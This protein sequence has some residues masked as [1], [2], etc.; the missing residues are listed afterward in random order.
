MGEHIYLRKRNEEIRRL[1]DDEG[2]KIEAI[3]VKLG[4]SPPSI[5]RVMATFHTKQIRKNMKILTTG[6][7]GG[8]N[9]NAL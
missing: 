5:S 3:S 7:H 6:I 1:R 8:E 9:K 2:W 4:V